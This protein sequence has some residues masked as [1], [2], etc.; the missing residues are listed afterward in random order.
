MAKKRLISLL[1]L[2]AALYDGALGV[3]FLI[4][5]TM[6]FDIF[7][8]TLPNHLGYVRF[9]AALLIVFAIMFLAI[10]V[11]PAANRGLIPYGILLKASYCGIVFYYWFTGGI[12]F[13]W[14]PFAIADLGFGLLFAAAYVHLGAKAKS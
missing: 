8:V 3:T 12:P 1:F 14:K 4:L 13:M 9:P 6:L 5:P 11:R 2:A 7:G 10:A